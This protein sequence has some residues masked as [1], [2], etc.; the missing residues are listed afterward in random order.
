[1]MVILRWSLG[2]KS[3]FPYIKFPSDN[4]KTAYKAGVLV[5]ATLTENWKPHASDAIIRDVKIEKGEEQDE[6]T[7]SK[8]KNKE[9]LQKGSTREYY[10]MRITGELDLKQPRYA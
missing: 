10:R 9:D 1:M 2:L 7:P 8:L 3:E 6:D 5:I 4:L